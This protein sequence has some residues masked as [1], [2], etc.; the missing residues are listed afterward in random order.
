MNLPSYFKDFLAAIE[1]S[2]S[3]KEDQQAGH[4]TLR[5]RLA[6][7]EDFKLIHV[8]TFLQGS[9]KRNTAICRR[10]FSKRKRHFKS[11]ARPR[12][13]S[14]FRIP[15]PMPMAMRRGRPR[16]RHGTA[17]VRAQGLRDPE[18]HAVLGRRAR[19]AALR[20]AR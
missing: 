10:A 8:N 7:D 4:K 13:R 16:E 3:Y 1:P 2:P 14:C 12:R 17:G 9:Y 11:C 18:L 19:G 6:E 5:R 20:R 15:G